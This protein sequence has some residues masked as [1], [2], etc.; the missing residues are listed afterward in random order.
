MKSQSAV[1]SGQSV[2]VG[3]CWWLTRFGAR[4]MALLLSFAPPE[5]LS[6]EVCL[7]SFFFKANWLSSFFHLKLQDPPLFQ[8]LPVGKY[9]P[10]RPELVPW[11]KMTHWQHL[12]GKKPSWSLPFSPTRN[13]L[14]AWQSPA[15]ERAAVLLKQLYWRP[16]QTAK[17]LPGS[18]T[19]LINSLPHTS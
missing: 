10:V 13:S 3:R 5:R 1:D 15:R 14:A 11:Q 19:S 4:V 18:R 9:R 16:V 12:G 8:W 2:P 6:T 17:G 7:F